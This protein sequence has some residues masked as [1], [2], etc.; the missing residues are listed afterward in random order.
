MSTLLKACLMALGAGCV[1]LFAGGFPQLGAPS[2]YHGGAMLLLGVLLAGLS[3]WGALR[4][5]KGNVLRLCFGLFCSFLAVIGLV[6][7]LRYGC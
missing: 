7:L 3:L 6:A 5:A 1:L 4:L 2:L